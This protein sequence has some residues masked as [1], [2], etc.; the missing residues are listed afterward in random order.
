MQELQ[1]EK[2]SLQ[3]R[4]SEQS[5]K[6]SS[7]QSRLDEQR[8]RAEELHRQGTSDMAFKCHD[9]QNE[10]TIAKDTLNARDKQIISLNQL[11]ENS[12]KIIDRQEVEWTLNSHD[13]DKSLV[14]RLENDL[15]VKS[16][17]NKRLK[18]K[19]KTEMINR[20]AL[21]DLMD[22]IIAE[23][24]DEIEDLKEKLEKILK[25][26]ESVDKVDKTESFFSK[27]ENSVLGMISEYEEPDILRKMTDP[28]DLRLLCRNPLMVSFINK[29]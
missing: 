1:Q 5:I 2:D 12:K 11:L 27:K 8:M 7:L 21:P 28:S 22:T 18:E 26:T 13:E 10:L 14:I 16:D 17:E 24:N 3:D 25:N 23:K 15:K 9:L 29:F 4:M 19:I 20:L 6:I